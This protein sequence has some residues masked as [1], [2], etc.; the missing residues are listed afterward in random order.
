M[1]LRRINPDDPNWFRNA[2]FV[3]KTGMEVITNEDG[4]PI[5]W[6]MPAPLLPRKKTQR[7]PSK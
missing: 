7:R 2:R 1:R 4:V 5:M 3:L 6:S